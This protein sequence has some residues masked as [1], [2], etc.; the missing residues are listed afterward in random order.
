MIEGMMEK[1]FITTNFDAVMNWA[2]TGS[3]VAHDFWFGLLCR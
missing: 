3:F 1:N 2:K